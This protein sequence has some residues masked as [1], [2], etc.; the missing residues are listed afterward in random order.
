[1]LDTLKA[2]T[3]GEWSEGPNGIICNRHE[4]EGGIIDRVIM[5]GE[6][7]LVFNRAG[8]NTLHGFTTRD[9]AIRAFLSGI[10]KTLQ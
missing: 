10:G 9:S 3:A 7:F 4:D 1:M 2:N 6:W 5:T 8:L